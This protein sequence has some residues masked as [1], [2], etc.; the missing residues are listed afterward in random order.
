MIKINK[1]NNSPTSFRLK[2]IRPGA[3]FML[4]NNKDFYIATDEYSDMNSR[5][6][7]NLEN[8]YI[9]RLDPGRTAICVNLEC[10][11]N[12]L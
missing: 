10:E 1:V 4:E 9:I 7:V 12:I 6:C 3:T 2:D 11:V 5:L 8:G